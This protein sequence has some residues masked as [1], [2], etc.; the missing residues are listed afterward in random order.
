MSEPAAVEPIEIC[1]FWKSRDH[2]THV[3][4]EISEYH[5]HRLINLR[6]W[7]TGADGID[8]PTVKGIALGIRKLPEL[9][10]G[11]DK[12]LR[13]ARELGLLADDREREAS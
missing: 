7:Q 10:A 9:A 12:A 6:I 1:K 2:S 3:R 5:G 8:R 11:I 13:K 4:I